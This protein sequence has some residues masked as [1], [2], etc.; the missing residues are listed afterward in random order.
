MNFAGKIQFNEFEPTG[1]RLKYNVRR[2][3][4][5]TDFI[6]TPVKVSSCIYLN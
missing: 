3:A 2:F 1:L 5:K 6:R 4:K